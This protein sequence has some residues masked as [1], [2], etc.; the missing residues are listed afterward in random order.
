MPAQ[1]QLISCDMCFAGQV[2]S[3]SRQM[4]ITNFPS[5]VAASNKVLSCLI[6]CSLACIHHLIVLHSM[7]LLQGKNGRMY[8]KES[9]CGDGLYI[10][11][12]ASILSK[13]VLDLIP[14]LVLP[15][16][17]CSLFFADESCFCPSTQAL[18][19]HHPV[20][21]KRSMMHLLQLH[22]QPSICLL[23]LQAPPASEYLCSQPELWTQWPNMKL[24]YEMS[25]S[26]SLWL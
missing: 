3:S 6:Q 22:Q 16:L 10:S 5:P 15:G 23:L 1:V 17:G 20:V 7:L 18:L 13:P 11:G 12:P 19:C 2:F 14:G 26:W 8:L 25:E 9:R 24:A 21:V 4:A